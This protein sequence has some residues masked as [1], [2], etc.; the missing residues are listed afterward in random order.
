M[1]PGVFGTLAFLNPWILAGLI[2]LPA[3]WFLLRV[4]PPAPRLIPFPA[5]RF[6]AGLQPEDTTAHHT[7][8]W[9]LLLRLLATALII[10]ALAQPVTNPDDALPDHGPLRIIMDNSWA[11]AQSW[12][13]QKREADSLLNRAGR[14][15]R[16][17]YIMTTAPEPGQN[18][19]L[20]HG[21]LSKGQADSILQGL[22]PLPWPADYEEAEK[23]LEKNSITESLSSF[24]LSHGLE[25]TKAGNFMRTLQNQGS[26]RLIM[27]DKSH[28][29]LL[30]RPTK[31]IGPDLKIRLD[32]PHS[33]SSHIPLS[34]HALGAEGQVLDLQKLTI[35]PDKLP[36]EIT[37]DIPRAIRNQVHQIHLANRKGAGAVLLLDNSFKRRIVGIAA[38]SGKAE[39]APLIESSFYLKR[40][41]EPYADIYTNTVTELIEKAPAV[42][43][44]PDIG[45]MPPEDLN[46][47]EKWIR[48]GG[49]LL[50]FA[51][52]NM[53]QGEAF[54][55][56]VPIR[57]GGRALD[58]SLTWETPVSLDEFPVS[59]PFSGLEIQEDIIV[60]RQILA[61]PI[62]GLEKLTWASLKDG[63]PL[64]TADT[65][66][67]GLLVLI[68]TTATPHWSN[69]PLSGLFVQILRRIINLS[70][71]QIQP[72][73]ISG[74]L[75]PLIV[76][77]G[78]GTPEQP[79][80]FAQ[81]IDSTTLQSIQPASTHPPG[82]YGKAGHQETLNIGT[83]LPPLKTFST[84]PS[85]V[86]K[87]TYGKT[88]EQE[89]MPF[90]LSMAFI[91]FLFDWLIMM[92]I[93][94]GGRFFLP[95]MTATAACIAMLFLA[96]PAQAETSEDMIRYASELHLAY[97]RSGI[98]SIDYKTHT[99]LEA[100]GKVLTRRT[101]I[102]PAGVV[103]LNPE[104]DELSF[105]PLIYW[106]ITSEGIKPS[107]KALHNIQNYLD[108]GG[109]ILFDTRDRLSTPQQT[110]GMH[111]GRNAKALRQMIGPLNIPPLVPMLDD[112]VL[113]KSFYLLHNL[114]GRYEG[115]IIWIEEE[116][117]SGRDGVSSVI[118]GSH[119]WAAA[120]AD[121]HDAAPRISG[122]PQQQEMALRFGINL[123]MYALTGNYKADQ[124][125]LPHILE[126]LGQ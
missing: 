39:T 54:L 74:I 126:R 29:P 109:T 25:E 41:L 104:T 73:N 80:S 16:E 45:A 96:F 46:A 69:L 95:R 71:H 49:L 9:I 40:A 42:I 50:R 18:A 91:L 30:L 3:L 101:S 51:G 123:V 31:S 98:S 103:A 99:G 81:P 88:H 121:S 26:L 111:G 114:P 17:I 10:L 19:P 11:A 75:Q 100:L 21:P 86:E 112:H 27:P 36:Q 70:G 47:L 35:N 5:A 83:N 37:F 55:T 92:L 33:I 79:K 4:T 64:V 6:V 43:I 77:N 62:E 59:S 116:S 13:L 68:H 15:Q 82:I 124:V 90:L 56:P 113:T 53:T 52:P 2:F 32:A 7:P 72:G 38:P 87:H 60:Q 118:I 107:D 119:D 76:L 57:K 108:H 93:Q 58:G 63:T 125:H 89:L 28:L 48:K 110:Q 66:D 120:W 102:E 12:D 22:N 20:H 97:I 85:G 44:L 122:G 117:A 105:F 115:G 1:T 23:L 67:K 78:Y 84:L 8:W 65:M 94:R 24:W 34:I 14:E 106:P 61:E